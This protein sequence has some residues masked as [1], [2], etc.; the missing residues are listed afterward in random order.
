MI[1][2]FIGKLYKIELP[3]YR[4]KNV[5]HLYQ[6]KIKIKLL[7][8]HTIKTLTLYDENIIKLRDC[9]QKRVF[10]F[11]YTERQDNSRTYPI[12]Y[13]NVASF[14]YYDDKSIGSLSVGKDGLETKQI[15]PVVI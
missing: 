12:W 9:D 3:V 10:I 4:G 1:E 13:N 15:H 6:Q 5:Y 7:G 14:E 2:S 8:T 11:H